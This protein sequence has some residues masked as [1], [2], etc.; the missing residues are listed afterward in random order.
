M[1]G[2]F[3]TVPGHQVEYLHMEKL[4][5]CPLTR[6]IAVYPAEHPLSS[7]LW[8]SLPEHHRAVYV[9]VEPC[10]LIQYTV[11]TYGWR[12]LHCTAQTKKV[13]IITD[14][15]SEGLCF[16]GILGEC[17]QVEYP[18]SHHLSF[19]CPSIPFWELFSLLSSSSTH[20][21]WGLLYF[22]RDPAIVLSRYPS[23]PSW[24][25][26]VPGFLTGLG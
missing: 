12:P 11:A 6:N 8:Q 18:C 5:L 19:L 2:A 16:Q 25:I 24:P 22:F 13:F 9:A 23:D 21:P 14:G 26:L 15:S 4:L 10:G 17:A 3:S 1:A 7:F 20:V